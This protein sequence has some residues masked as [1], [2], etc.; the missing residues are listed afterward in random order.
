MKNLVY[1]QI[2]VT[3][4]KARLRIHSGLP[5]QGSV[6]ILQLQNHRLAGILA[7]IGRPGSGSRSYSQGQ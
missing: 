7:E 4:L 3:K 5:S 6:V 2:Q 1:E